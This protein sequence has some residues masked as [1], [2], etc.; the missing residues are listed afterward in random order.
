M[1]MFLISIFLFLAV[2]VNIARAQLIQSP[3]DT[4]YDR[5]F[6]S[7]DFYSDQ[8]SASL[9]SNINFEGRYKRFKVY[10]RN[11]FNSDITKLSENFARDYNSLKF[12]STYSVTRNFS[13]GAGVLSKSLSDNKDIALN[14]GFNNFY[15]A[16]L[17]FVPSNHFYINSKLGL[18]NEEQIG[19]RN[20]GIGG[21]LES[22]LRN[23]NLNNFISNGKLYLYHDNLSEKINYNYE[24]SADVTRQFS[25]NS[26]NRSILR[27]YSYRSDFYTPATFSIASTFNVKNNIQSRYE[28]Y[29]F[30]GDNLDYKFSNNLKLQ[31]SGVYYVKSIENDYKYKPSQ[32]NI[33]IEN[34][35]DSKINENQLQASAKLEFKKGKFF[36]NVMALYTER[37]E[38]HNLINADNISVLQQRELERI[39]KD[40]N[41]N[42]R[43]SAFLA[44]AYY[45]ISNTNYLRF[46]G[47]SSLLKYDTDSKLNYDDRDELAL[48]AVLTH[49]FTNLRNFDVE[50]AFEINNS[51]LSYLFKEKSSN[52][53]TNKVYKLTSVSTFSPVKQLVTRN[54]FQVL[55]NY[56]VYKFEDL[57]S[58]IQSFSFRQLYI[59]DSTFYK[60]TKNLTLNF[61]G[62]LKIYEQGQYNEKN[63]SVRP[64]AYYDERITNAQASYAV[65]EYILFALGFKHFIQRQYVYD[66]GSKI[67]KRTFTTYGPLLRVEFLL[68]RNSRVNFMGG[69]DF[70]QSSDNTLT[71]ISKNLIINVLWNI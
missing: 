31:I 18:K 22:E 33:V 68:S 39:E 36:S 27:A 69:L 12:I 34:I 9:N 25:D 26:G 65:N 30:L 16:D 54:Q 2:T 35:Y 32:G 20:S 46:M 62:S 58:Q 23:L 64:L 40:K 59:S 44:E 41:N 63:F 51:E 28:Q 50:T 42:S 4:V 53:N 15:F 55:A 57:V 11:G 13:A 66:K 21:V 19:E 48:N 60:F 70:I 52:N 3:R 61:F 37:N 8:N 45:V 67:L 14:K 71:N 5:N 47:S 1:K 10:F 29:V 49:R 6:L 38:L 56:T 24:L 17:E 7:T 43:S